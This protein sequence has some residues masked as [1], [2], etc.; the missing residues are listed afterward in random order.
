M[1]YP[2]KSPAK[3]RTSVARKSQTPILTASNSSSLVRKC[4]AWV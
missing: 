4:E 1:A 3:R 2:T